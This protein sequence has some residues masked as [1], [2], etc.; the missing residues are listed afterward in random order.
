MRRV[1]SIRFRLVDTAGSEVGIV[2]SDT[3]NID[4][5]DTVHT[6]DGRR[7]EVV[8]IYD[9]EFGR[10]GGV[11]AT[12]VV[13]EGADA[14]ADPIPEEQALHDLVDGLGLGSH[15]EEIE[16]LAQRL[17]RHVEEGRGE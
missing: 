12:L 9:D 5:G 11:H 14:S 2:D 10:E 17:R 7:V 1:G 4:V 15:L 13:D 16:R 8:E 3:V 6:P